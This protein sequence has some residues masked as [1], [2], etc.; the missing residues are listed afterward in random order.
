MHKNLVLRSPRIALK[1]A[2]CVRPTSNVINRTTNEGHAMAQALSRRPLT[3]EN[4]LQCYT[5]SCEAYGDKRPLQQVLLRVHQ[6]SR[7][8]MIPAMHHIPSPITH[9][10]AHSLVFPSFAC[11]CVYVCVCVCVCIY[12]YI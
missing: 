8:S 11:V 1:C 3:V 4:R 7:A 12:I 6:F 9:T 2:A 10:T 5:S